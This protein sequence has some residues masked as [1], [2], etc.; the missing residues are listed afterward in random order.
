MDPAKFLRRYYFNLTTARCQ[1]FLYGGC[2]GNHNNFENQTDCEVNTTPS[3][4]YKC[5]RVI[6]GLKNIFRNIKN[7]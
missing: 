1:L 2:G 3:T 7:I 4:V 6:D 5:V